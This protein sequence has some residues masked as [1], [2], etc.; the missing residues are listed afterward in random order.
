MPAAHA[1]VRRDLEA[2]LD[3]E[4]VKPR[5]VGEF[6]DGALMWELAGRGVGIVPT[7]TLV[8]AQL[9]AQHALELVARVPSVTQ[10]FYVSALESRQPSPVVSQLFGYDWRA[11]AAA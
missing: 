10:R 8:E 11:A 4:Q 7:A 2:W 1:A 6:E 5:V 9:K 3:A